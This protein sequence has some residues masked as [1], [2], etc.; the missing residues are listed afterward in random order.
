MCCVRIQHIIRHGREDPRTRGVRTAKRLPTARAPLL[1]QGR[2][3]PAQ[4]A[5]VVLNALKTKVTVDRDHRDTVR[6]RLRSAVKCI[7]RTH[8]NPPDL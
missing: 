3:E 4:I 8:S 1:T 5:A 7:L 6:A 2:R